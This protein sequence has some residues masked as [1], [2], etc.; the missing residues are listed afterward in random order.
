MLSNDFKE[1]PNSSMNENLN[2][3]KKGSKY[4]SK[5]NDKIR[6]FGIRT[7]NSLS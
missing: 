1:K 7:F 5:I 4:S 2:Y 3:F 6:D